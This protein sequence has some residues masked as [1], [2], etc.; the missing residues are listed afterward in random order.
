MEGISYLEEAEKRGAFLVPPQEEGFWK[1]Y[2]IQN[3]KLYAEFVREETAPEAQGFSPE[4]LEENGAVVKAE[5]PEHLKTAKGRK[6]WNRRIW[7]SLERC[8][9]RQRKRSFL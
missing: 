4:F 6:A 2:S 3:G 9:Q 7:R 5:L 1:T 8:C